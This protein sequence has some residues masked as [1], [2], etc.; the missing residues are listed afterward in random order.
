[1][2]SFNLLIVKSNS[3]S[4]LLASQFSKEILHRES[5]PACHSFI[6]YSRGHSST[7]YTVCQSSTRLR[8]RSLGRGLLDNE[9]RLRCYLGLWRS[10]RLSIKGSIA[11]SR[12]IQRLSF[13][14]G[15][16][17]CGLSIQIPRSC[18]IST[19]LMSLLVSIRYSRGL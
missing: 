19:D 13:C 4:W 15:S 3:S 1:V 8:P 6:F 11:A 17:L 7:S 10:P 12:S 18:L 2:I 9:T 16:L 14:F 5:I